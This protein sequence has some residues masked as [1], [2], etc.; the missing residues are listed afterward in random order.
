MG[1][2]AGGVWTAPAPTGLHIEPHP[3]RTLS[4]LLPSPCVQER[5]GAD[6]LQRSSHLLTAVKLADFGL[7]AIVGEA[8]ARWL[9]IVC[10]TECSQGLD[11]PKVDKKKQNKTKIN[12]D[13]FNAKRKVA[14]ANACSVFSA[15]LLT[16]SLC[17]PL[18]TAQGQCWGQ[19]DRDGL[20]LCPCGW[21][22][23]CCPDP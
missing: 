23:C 22:A 12:K 4:S 6:Q 19:A 15:F 20:L 9:F 2:L 1:P 11:H 17:I 3:T 8:R 21:L 14:C 18:P 5:F 10:H 16:T 7:A 13:L